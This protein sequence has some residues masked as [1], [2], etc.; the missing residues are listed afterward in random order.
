MKRSLSVA[1]ALA[2]LLTFVARAE[3]A[4]PAKPSPKLVLHGDH[5]YSGGEVDAKALA[6]LLRPIPFYAFDNGVGRGR[7]SFGEQAKL[8]KELGYDGI[9]F[10]GAQQILQILKALDAQGLKLFNIYVGGQVGPKGPSYDP[11]LKQAI[12]QLKDRATDIW[13]FISGSVSDDDEQAV[14]MVREIAGLAEQSGLRVVLYP[15]VGCY[16]ARIEDAVRIA[17]KANRKNV[18]ATFNLC[19]FL[20]LDD[21]KNIEKRLKEAGP[22]LF[23]VSINGADR[24]ETNKM[25]W[26]RLIQTLDR[27]TFDVGALVK[28]LKRLGY[29][30]PVGLQCYA[31]PGEPRDNLKRSMEAWRKI[32][33]SLGE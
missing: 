8:L 28:T 15:H 20:K 33:A 11:N 4:P 23:L 19:H 21:E 17:K 22:Y 30:G 24:G 5:P 32:Q 13:L 18:G 3:D 6:Q 27:G 1:P 2:L 12:G 9:G 31:I 25:G 14:K 16:V 10:S 26:D 29:K 7:L